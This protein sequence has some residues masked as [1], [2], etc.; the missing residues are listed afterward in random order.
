MNA[1][2]YTYHSLRLAVLFGLGLLLTSTYAQNWTIEV[3]TGT[4]FKAP[5]SITV[6]QEG[7]PVTKIDGV[8]YETKAWINAES[9]AGLTENYYSVRVGYYPEDAKPGIWGVGYEVELLHDKAYYISGSG[10]D[11]EG[12]IQHFELSDGLN[13]GLVNLVGRYP[14]YASEHYPDGQFQW[15]LRGGM[16]PVITAPATKIRGLESGT[17]SHKGTDAYYWFAGWGV[18]AS[19]QLRLFLIPQVA[20]SSEIKL[21]AA[22]TSNRIAGGTAETFV[23]G[24][25]ITFG[26]T[27]QIP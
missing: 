16:G 19:T 9:I 22:D 23:T 5:S 17:R 6:K 2:Y 15:L 18:Q 4:S 27:I 21:T 20:L 7:H 8:R 14:F 3:H 1:I 10:D 12:V 26:V 25:H 11:P 24:A 13:M